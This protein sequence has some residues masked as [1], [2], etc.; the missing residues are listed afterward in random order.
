MYGMAQMAQA[1]QAAKQQEESEIAARERRIGSL[2]RNIGDMLNHEAL[3]IW[4][5]FAASWDVLA[6]N[7]DERIAHESSSHVS[8]EAKRIL[9]VV[10]RVLHNPSTS[11]L[12]TPEKVWDEILHEIEDEYD[13]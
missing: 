4:D 9:R 10:H 5:T 11:G 8:E 6:R 7:I 2:A 13:M 3:D 12:A 1:A